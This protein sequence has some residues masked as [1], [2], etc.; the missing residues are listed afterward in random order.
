MTRRAGQVAKGRR[1]TIGL[2]QGSWRDALWRVLL[3]LPLPVAWATNHPIPH[4]GVC[5]F[6]CRHRTSEKRQTPRPETRLSLFH[7]AHSIFLPQH[8]PENHP[9]TAGS[10][11]PLPLVCLLP[12]GLPCP[13]PRCNLNLLPPLELVN[14]FLRF[15]L[16]GTKGTAPKRDPVFSKFLRRAEPQEHGGRRALRSHFR[17]G[18]GRGG[19]LLAR[20]NTLHRTVRTNEAAAVSGTPS[21]SC[22]PPGVLPGLVVSPCA[23]QPGGIRLSPHKPPRAR[24]NSWTGAEPNGPPRPR[25]PNGRFQ[26]EG[27]TARRIPER[28]DWEV[29][30]SLRGRV[31]PRGAVYGRSSLASS[32]F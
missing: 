12:S 8:R 17:S 13:V 6:P 4:I 22:A 7:C 26:S 9:T 16:P 1:F 21:G 14:R 27:P 31:Q 3:L 15:P 18:N 20:G 32:R 11:A 2:P 10:S 25:A 24:R 5:F 28:T 30:R 23:L 29:Q 19:L